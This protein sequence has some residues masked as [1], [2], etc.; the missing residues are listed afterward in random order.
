MFF[1]SWLDNVKLTMAL[2]SSRRI[3]RR[4]PLRKRTA[5]NYVAAQVE[6]M[7]ERRLLS[8]GT[9]DPT[10]GSG[11]TVTTNFSGP[12]TGSPVDLVVTQPDGKAIMVVNSVSAAGPQMVALRY[13][14]DGSLDSSFG[15]GGAADFQFHGPDHPAIA[16]EFSDQAAAAVLDSA[17]RLV[18]VGSTWQIIN[19]DVTEEFAVTRLNTDGSVDTTFGN[20]GLATV[21]FGPVGDIATGDV[22]TSVALDASG[23]IIIAG[24]TDRNGEDFAVARLNTDGSLDTTFA[25]GGTTTF[26]FGAGT[27][28]NYAHHVAVDPSGRIVVEGYTDDVASPTNFTFA[29]ARL[30]VDG[31]LDAN[32]G[33]GGTEAIHLGP[34]GELVSA[35]PDSMTVDASGRILVAGNLDVQG[36][37]FSNTVHFTVARLNAS[38]G[39]LDDSFGASGVQTV[40]FGGTDFVNDVAVDAVGQILL[41]GSTSLYNS[42]PLHNS[43]TYSKFAVARL[44]SADGSLDGSFGT[45]GETTIDAG[46]FSGAANVAVDPAGNIL[47]AGNGDSPLPNGGAGSNPALVRLTAAGTADNSFGSNGLVVTKLT[48]QQND[49]AAGLVVTQPDGKSLVVG[50]SGAQGTLALARYNPDGSLDSSFGIAGRVTFDDASG[51]DLEPTSVTVDNSGCILVAGEFPYWHSLAASGG[52]LRLNIDG[53]LDTT[54]GVGGLVSV[55]GVRAVTTDSSGR[56]LLAENNFVTLLGQS[57]SVIRLNADGSRDA[58]FGNQGTANISFGGISFFNS[59]VGLALDAAGR[60]VVVGSSGANQIGVVRLNTDGTVDTTFGS[61]GETTFNFGS[62]L[63]LDQAQA[64]AIDGA[65]RIDV[66]GTTIG[67]SGDFNTGVFQLTANGMLNTA[68][69]TGGKTVFS[70]GLDSPMFPDIPFPISMA[71]DA[72]GEIALASSAIVDASGVRTLPAIVD[73]LKPDGRPDV[74]FGIAG[75]FASSIAGGASN[76][77]AGVAFDASG[78]LMVASTKANPADIGSNSLGTS[79]DFALTRYLGHDPIVEAGADKF[80]AQ[81]QAAITALQTTTPIGSPRVVIHADNPAEMANVTAA[82]AHLSVSASGPTV[83]VLLDLD[84]GAYTP[85]RVSVPAGLRLILDGDGGA[86]GTGTFASDASGPALTVV[87]GDVLIR[88]GA[89]VTGNGNFPAIRVLGGQLTVRNSTITETTTANKAALVIKGGQVDLGDSSDPGNNTIGVN[90]TGFLIRLKGANDVMAVGNT[91][92]VNGKTLNDNYQ[93]ADAIQ[94]SVD[95]LAGGTVYWVPDNVFVSANSGS[96][97]N[98]VNAVPVGGTVNVQTGA[99]GAYDVGAKLLTINFDNGVFVSQQ[100]D[101]LDPTK[102]SLVVNDMYI[103]NPN[104]TITFTAGSSPAEIDLKIN[105]FPKG[106]FLPTGRLIAYGGS[107]DTITVDSSVLM[108]A[109]LYGGGSGKLTGG[110]GNNVLIGS[111]GDVLTGG[112]G[113]NLL[114]GAGSKLQSTSGQDILISGSVFFSISQGVFGLPEAALAAMMAE[115]TSADSLAQRIANLSD[116]TASPLFSASRKNGNYFLLDSGPNQ[117]VFDDYRADKVI[118]GSGPAWIFAGSADKITGL[119]AADVLSIVGP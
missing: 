38:D 59:T 112:A 15:S 35:Y 76:T 2:N 90:G 78:R 14:T 103:F 96:I 8:A 63:N 50:T 91:F 33:S 47:L 36:P 100:A 117:T 66:A 22:A 70:F 23:R 56:I 27:S 41:A 46:L 86:P 28:R 16:S 74:D 94:H 115:W 58:S 25:N 12:A 60:V 48:G 92:Q 9:V 108:P 39:S 95:G 68:F 1:R 62:N 43:Y 67:S 111:A 101:S 97:Q 98:G 4:S 88:D 34:P 7:E 54:F 84:T 55:N 85:G 87:S 11:G 5:G 119:T 21:S 80:A 71:V 77:A 99:S 79:E 24:D 93:I 49:V 104:R 110:S 72:A 17:G 102:R 10:F 42:G 51:L 52:V 57:N 32:F 113:R 73:V 118:A 3:R 83:E 19:G 64:V 109:W 82:L 114:I 31:T 69:G 29:V 13:N 105:N 81:L 37:S 20:A 89:V 106:T 75:Q 45:A 107:S 65:G 18:V 61:G 44:N 26:G 6:V 53:S 30:Q 116:N 40:S